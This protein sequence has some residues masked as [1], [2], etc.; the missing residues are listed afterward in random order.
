M[1]QLCGPEVEQPRVLDNATKAVMGVGT[2]LGESVLIRDRT[3]RWKAVHTEGG[4]AD[5]PCH[6]EA[7]FELLKYLQKR[8]KT[9][10]VPIERGLSGPGIEAIYDFLQS[11]NSTKSPVKT[12]PKEIVRSGLAGEDPV[13]VEAL[14]AFAK[15]YGAE[16]GNFAIRTLCYGG[17]YLTG[18]LTVG[19]K[20]YL[21]KSKGFFVS[22]RCAVG[23]FLL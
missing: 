15:I 19:L 4:Y 13:A 11:K 14:E 6:D 2:G 9:R 1:H 7:E 16:A 5:F 3:G 8:Y 17:I 18:S 12:G 20:E 21:A 22:R 23:S 10:C